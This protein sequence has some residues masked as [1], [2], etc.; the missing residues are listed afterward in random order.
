MAKGTIKNLSNVTEELNAL[1]TR[2]EGVFVRHFRQAVWAVFCEL[3]ETTPQFT[4][5]AAANWNIGLG[6]PDFSVD[7]G[8]GEQPEITD[9]KDG[10]AW[11]GL[12]ARRVGDHKWVEFAKLQNEYKLFLIKVNTK[13]YISNGV[14][15]DTDHD[16]KDENYL[17]ELQN[18]SYWMEKLRDVNQPYETVG[19]ILRLESWRARLKGDNVG[20]AFFA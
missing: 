11:V 17:M 19:A 9:T 8:A 1:A 13:V 16:T 15:G 14:T 6:A 5:R 7:S 18:P 10:G 4:G 3:V 2:A 12:R 20:K